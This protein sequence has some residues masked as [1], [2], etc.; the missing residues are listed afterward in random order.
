[1]SDTS[2]PPPSL[3]AE[4]VAATRD[5]IVAAARRRFG[6][7]G[8]AGT[9]IDA[10]AKDA[11]L[12][13]GAVYHHFSSKRDLFAAV[14]AVVERDAQRRAGSAPI[15]DGTVL[16]VIAHGAN[17][18]LD[19]VLDPETQRITLVDAPAVLGPEPDGPPEED[20]G[21]AALRQVLAAAVR[22]GELAKVD[23]DATAHL[24]RGACLQAALY[25]AR[26]PDA[27][28]ARRRVG[29]ALERMIRGLG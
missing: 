23:A 8:Y 7:D 15:G 9:S 28:R 14:Y 12:T 26:A 27:R 16:D 5:A 10:V 29:P 2:P 6:R 11:R 17:A 18:Y 25:I 1:V 20:P 13:K 3:R 4:Q 24:I 22:R 21:L 19:A